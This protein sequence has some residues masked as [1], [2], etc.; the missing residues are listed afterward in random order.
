[1]SHRKIFLFKTSFI[2]YF[3]QG[4]NIHAAK[5]PSASLDKNLKVGW[6]EWQSNIFQFLLRLLPKNVN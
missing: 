6:I 5:K 1:M 3:D 2:L 4:V